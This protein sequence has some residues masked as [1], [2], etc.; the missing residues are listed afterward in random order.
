MS[1]VT[2]FFFFPSLLLW[3]WMSQQKKNKKKIIY[4]SGILIAYIHAKGMYVKFNSVFFFCGLHEYKYDVDVFVCGAQC[5]QIRL[6]LVR[7]CFSCRM[8][9]F[10]HTVHMFNVYLYMPYYVLY[11][12]D[13]LMAANTVFTHMA[14]G[15]FF[16]VARGVRTRQHTKSDLHYRLTYH[17]E[18]C[19]WVVYLPW[20]GWI[21]MNNA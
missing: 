12:I 13:G 21:Y 2:V 16:C 17:A 3:T 15:Y 20:W 14:A 11:N 6:L 10:S 8:N 1:Y 4:L 5:D 7:N 19:L 18:I 9:L